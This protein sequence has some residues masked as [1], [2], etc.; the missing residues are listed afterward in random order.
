[1]TQTQMY[2]ARQGIIS[3]EMEHVAKIENLDAEL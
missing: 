2:F 3:K 1:M